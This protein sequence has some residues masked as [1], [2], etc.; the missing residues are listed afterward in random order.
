MGAVNWHIY[1][2]CPLLFLMS[3]KLNLEAVQKSAKF[4]FALLLLSSSIISN[5][6][7]QCLKQSQMFSLL[8]LCTCV[9]CIWYFQSSLRSET[10]SNSNSLFSVNLQSVLCGTHLCCMT[11]RQGLNNHTPC[12]FDRFS[13]TTEKSWA[14]ECILS[15]LW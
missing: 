3:L 2:F 14:Q 9:G 4:L 7:E 15:L 12:H 5:T 13:E 11:P 1:S 6:K 10:L 8:K